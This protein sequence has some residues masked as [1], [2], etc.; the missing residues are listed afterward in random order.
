MND[1]VAIG[2]VVFVFVRVEEEIGRIEHPDAIFVVLE[3]R[4]D[5][6]AIDE[7][8]DVLE[9]AVAVAVFVDGD[10]VPAFV[11]VR[12]RRRDH[13]ENGAEVFVVANDF[14]AG[15]KGILEVLNDPHAPT[16]V[17]VE[18]DRLANVGLGGDEF[19]FEVA[20]NFEGGERFLRRFG[21]GGEIADGA[22]AGEFFDEVFDFLAGG[23]GCGVLGLEGWRYQEYSESDCRKS[24]RE[25]PAA[26]RLKNEVHRLRW[27]QSPPQ[28]ENGF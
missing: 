4:A 6:E 20:G 24:A 23:F 2:H 16:F 1:R 21:L 18:K 14:E 7:G 19:D 8:F 3:R 9:A 27:L 17:E 13:I 22:S 15:W 25:K 5:I 26:F 10:F 28:V 11:V 12:R